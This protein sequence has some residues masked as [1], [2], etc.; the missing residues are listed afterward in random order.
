M[1]AASKAEPNPT[2]AERTSDVEMT[3]TRLFDAPPRLVFEAW[4]K[5]ELLLRW[6]AP[7]AL[8]ISFVSCEIDPRTGGSYRFVFRHPDAPQPMAFFGRYLEVV[9]PSRMVWTNEEAG[10][11][12]QVTTLTFE[13]RGGQTLLTLCDRYPSKAVLDEAIA[14]G[15]TGG[16]EGSF[17][18]LDELLA[19][20]G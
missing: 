8:G 13:A 15:G 14:S 19:E 20:L 12:A 4:T 3:V 18:Q 11:T 9:P 10:E 6:W 17:E 5:P 1:D 16:V 7:R 2:T